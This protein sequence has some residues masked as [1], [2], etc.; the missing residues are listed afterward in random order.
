MNYHGV[1]RPRPNPRG[2][3]RPTDRP[4]AA[5]EIS[6][7]TWWPRTKTSGGPDGSTH[8]RP[9]LPPWE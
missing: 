1:V 6:Q 7:G 3:V 8:N 9:I 5:A 2:L 4:G